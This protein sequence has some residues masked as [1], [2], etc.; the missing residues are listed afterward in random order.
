LTGQFERIPSGEHN[1]FD[2]DA[3]FG[4]EGPRA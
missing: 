1:I 3:Q 2:I 4:E